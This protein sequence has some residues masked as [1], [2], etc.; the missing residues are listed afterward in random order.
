M[1]VAG[2]TRD[3]ARQAGD[4]R[5]LERQRDSLPFGRK[6]EGVDAREQ[7]AKALGVEER[8]DPRSLRRVGR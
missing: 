5:L 6:D 3:D 1:V 8:Q 4:E 7:L 2:A